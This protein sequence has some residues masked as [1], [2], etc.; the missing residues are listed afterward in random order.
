ME[1]PDFNFMTYINIDLE[2]MKK[3][4]YIINKKLIAYRRGK[5][6]KAS[7][8]LKMKR[9]FSRIKKKLLANER[10]QFWNSII[11][12][13]RETDS[14]NFLNYISNLKMEHLYSTFL[15]YLKINKK[16]YN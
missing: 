14:D 12:V 5:Y 7:E 4:A 1:K 3:K 2:I 6:F 15:D 16:L 8:V 11:E 13:D 10:E 9:E